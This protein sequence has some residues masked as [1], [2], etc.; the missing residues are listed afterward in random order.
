[1]IRQATPADVSAAAALAC[2]LFESLA[3]EEATAEMAA[4]IARADCAIFLAWA[5]EEAIG[6]AQCQLRR[7]Y[8]EGTT[9]SPVGHLEGVYVSPAHRRRGVARALLARCEAWARE[10]GC[11]EFASDCE[12]TN[13]DSLA[14]HLRMGFRE[15]NRIICFTKSLPSRQHESVL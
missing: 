4:L 6:F 8:V 7:D 10:L 11:D 9:T 2:R 14:F 3:P 5:E 13:T 15:A 12:L 1:M